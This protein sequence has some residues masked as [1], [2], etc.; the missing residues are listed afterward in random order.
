MLPFAD[1]VPVMVGIPVKI[2]RVDALLLQFFYQG[3]GQFLRREEPAQERAAIACGIGYGPERD[4]RQHG[5]DRLQLGMIFL[6][7][8]QE[9]IQLADLRQATAACS[10]EMRKLYPIKDAAR[11]RGHFQYDH[12]HGPST[13]RLHMNVFIVRQHRTPFRTGDGLYKVE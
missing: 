13:H 5:K 2:T 11:V 12:D 10:S 6:L 1:I 3:H 7:D 4:L 9:L 8:G